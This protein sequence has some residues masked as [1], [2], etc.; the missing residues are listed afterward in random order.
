[1]MRVHARKQVRH[2]LEA[3]CDFELSQRKGHVLEVR[4][5]GY[6]VFWDAWTDV[7]TGECHESSAGVLPFEA[8]VKA[9]QYGKLRVVRRPLATPT[10]RDNVRRSE[11]VVIEIKRMQFRKEFVLA[12]LELMDRGELSND[13]ADFEAKAIE[14]L[15]RGT[16][17]HAKHL[18]AMAMRGQKRGGAQ[19][20]KT[21]LERA[22][23]FEFS[24]SMRSGRTFWKWTRQWAEHGDEGLFDGYRNC[25][26][27]S[28]YSDEVRAF[29]SGKIEILLDEERQTLSAIAESVRYFIEKENE[30]RL[31]LPIPDE[32][33]D[34]VGY[35]YVR[36]L[37]LDLA[38]IGH[39]IRRK[40]WDSAYK[41]MH[42]IG[43]GVSTSR[44]LERVEIDEYTVDLMV[45]M[46]SVGLFDHLP[47]AIQ[48]F[49][50]LDGKPCRVTLS[51]ALDV[52]TRC[53]LAL[54]IV[55]QAH[56]SP[57]RD[58]IEMIYM[59]KAPISDAA[60]CRFVWKQ[61][62]AP[63]TIVLDR[64]PRYITDE[65]YAVLASLGITNM[66]APAGKPWL[67]PFV[68]R[69][70]RTIHED[71]LQRFMGR[72]FGSVDKKGDNDPELR[73]KLTLE[74]FLGWLVRWTVD[75]Y[76]NKWHSALG[77][78]PNQA[79]DRAVKECY[80]RSLTSAEM[81]DAFGVRVRRKI[82]PKGV[83]VRHIVY[84]NDALI[85]LA[86]TPGVHDVEVLRWHGDIGTISVRAD[87]GPWLS[88]SAT[89]PEWIGKTDIDIDVWI[90]N[91]KTER[92]DETRARRDAITD[93]NDES[94]RIK[95][96]AGLISLPRT[97]EQLE[98]DIARFSRHTDTAERRHEF[99]EYKDILADLDDA[100]E[101]LAPQEPSQD[102]P[103]P[104]AAD[105]MD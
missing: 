26:G 75:A 19:I 32:V 101:A 15:A 88:V 23:D 52:H 69:L 29:V 100:D 74:A 51:A 27:H 73:A 98:H 92:E 43:L 42:S 36:K 78:S 102:T 28:R 97:A 91:R 9:N 57:L 31:A 87:D 2:L 54:Q 35:D 67:K 17:R 47:P 99:G 22:Q 34:V 62:G 53:L 13:R 21:D 5:E 41:D 55:P 64:G 72:T 89:D 33:L 85:A 59:D 84:Q 38:P 56:Q 82:G 14:I 24:E 44:A 81:R 90:A 60:K 103:A 63:E 45:L 12:A 18:A 3:R 96:L 6:F 58:T 4:P 48:A 7:M 50:G 95:R 93:I 16:E 66:G 79:W 105:L 76:H 70:F 104:S 39:A 86:N 94:Y 49:I 46:K 8:V 11:R 61:G 83:V 71:L 68:E 37:V 80:P 1:M 30:R 20:R 25:G 40:G 77:M 65:A 10:P